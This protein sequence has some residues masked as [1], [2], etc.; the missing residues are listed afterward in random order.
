MSVTRVALISTIIATFSLQSACSFLF[1]QGPPDDH[2]RRVSFSCSESNTLPVLDMI[3]A[4]LNGLGAAV[5]D[6]TAENKDQVRV[7]GIGWLLLSGISAIYGFSKVSECNKAQQLRDERFYPGGV[8]APPPAAPPPAA[9]P[10]GA[11]PPAVAPPHAA[12]PPPAAPPPAA[13]PAPTP[14]ALHGR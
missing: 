11:L 13:A 14:P 8:A 9:P 1:V 5:V 12:A 2:A 4:G 3:W 6:D 7:V 10:P